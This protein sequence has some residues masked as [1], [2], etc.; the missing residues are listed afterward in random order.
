MVMHFI[1]RACG[2]KVYVPGPCLTVPEK[3]NAD[4]GRYWIFDVTSESKPAAL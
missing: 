4:K 3:V 1:V 2:T